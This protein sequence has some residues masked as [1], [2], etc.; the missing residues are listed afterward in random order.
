[1]ET[2]NGSVECGNELGGETNERVEGSTRSMDKPTGLLQRPALPTFRCARMGKEFADRLA[3]EDRRLV[4]SGSTEHIVRS[5]QP[6]PLS[7]TNIEEGTGH[8]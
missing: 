5:P 6:L 1:M 2:P 7:S 4:A 8:G 3:A